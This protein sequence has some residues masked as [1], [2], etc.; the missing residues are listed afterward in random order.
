MK[1]SLAKTLLILPLLQLITGCSYS[2]DSF[3]N[4]LSQ[5]LRS[6][7]DPETVIQA[8]PSYLILLDGMVENNPDDEVV[9][10]TSSNL[11]TVYVGLLEARLENNQEVSRT[12]QQLVKQ[13]QK[14]L[15]N[16]ALERSEL[17]ICIHNE[18]L[19]NLTNRSYME[20][21]QR[22][23]FATIDDIE[24]LYGIGRSW[25]SWLQI[26]AEDWNAMAQ[27]PHI[28]LIMETV[29]NMNGAYENAGGYMYLGVIN[30]LLPESLGGK[31]EIGKQH[32]DTA[33]RLTEG[34]NL[35]AKVLY[36]QYYSRVTF[37]EKLHAEL[38]EDV[39]SSTAT[40]S[41]MNLMNTLAKQKAKAL[42]KSAV[43]FF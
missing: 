31:P 29:S 39:L 33:I 13:Q 28:K 3:S 32:F 24:Y 36:A 26:N 4:S 38:I 21:E 10:N 40:E 43:E 6:S 15:V 1:N 20:F 2:F 23:K 34:R 12:E 8:L 25:I 37:N 5:A 18:E 7:D 22:L 19:C 42:K 17:A 9:L 27:M 14:K 16:K 41:S 11:I 35:M 30:S